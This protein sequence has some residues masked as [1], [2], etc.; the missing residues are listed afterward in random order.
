[1]MWALGIVA[2]LG[3][4]LASLQLRVI[5]LQR[6]SLT[7]AWGRVEHFRAE[8]ETANGLMAVISREKSPFEAAR[9]TEQ[10]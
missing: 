7:L 8:L 2:S 1:M 10:A 5:V 6:R 3:W 4:L 9:R